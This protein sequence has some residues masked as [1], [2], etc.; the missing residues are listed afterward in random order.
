MKIKTYTFFLLSLGFL[1]GSCGNNK[2][3][4]KEPAQDSTIQTN[5]AV[6]DSSLTGDQ[7]K[8]IVSL[9]PTS[10]W[11]Q[12]SHPFFVSRKV[13]ELV[14]SKPVYHPSEDEEMEYTHDHLNKA[15]MSKLNTKELIYYCLKY[16][17]SFAQICA[18][19][20]FPDST[21]TPKIQ[22]YLPFDYSGAM[23]SDWQQQAVEKRRDS[24]II[25]LN[26]F[27]GEHPDDIDTEYLNLLLSLEAVESIPTIAKIA[28]HSNHGFSYLM[29]LMKMKKYTP[30][31]KTGMYQQLY[32]D[33]SWN[34]GMRIEANKANL[35][36]IK[37]L[38]NDFYKTFTAK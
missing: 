7:E 38:A 35:D 10:E 24:V 30:F 9:H 32:G 14:N 37:T 16:P 18:G 29:L 28:S 12:R 23:L 8:E 34:Y 6:T 21:N 13:D 20:A 33:N 1:M 17:C 26:K 25:V 19:D 11:S 15:E 4:G 2:E 31:E 27:L 36:S 5:N 3:T 22:A